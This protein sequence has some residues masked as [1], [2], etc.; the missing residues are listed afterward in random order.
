MHIGAMVA[1]YASAI[2]VINLAF[3]IINRILPDLLSNYG[4]LGYASVS[5]IAWPISALLVLVPI[6]YVLEWIIRKDVRSM[7]AKMDIWVRRWRIYLTLFLTG[8]TIAVDVIT[9]INTYLN[10]E[11]TGRLVWKILAVFIIAS[12]IFAYYILDRKI[13]SEMDKNIWQKSI[14][15]LGL[16]IVIAS[17]VA[18]FAIAGS[19]AKQRSLR[20]DERRINDLSSIQWQIVNRWQNMGALPQALAELN[21]PISSFVVPKDPE[22]GQLYEYRMI[23]SSTVNSVKT[24]EFELCATF[25]MPSPQVYDGGINSVV[26]TR[27]VAYSI[28]GDI[29]SHGVGRQCFV[30]TIDTNRYPLINSAKM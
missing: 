7:P 5:D 12:T 14:S 27:P 15:I 10:G 4:Y 16:F 26:P 2:A 6:L 23:S 21:D 30:R 11:I 25:S 28:V 29:W 18:G 3:A 1:L 13:N 8:A 19:P 17:I 24:A 9:L 20:F 22:T